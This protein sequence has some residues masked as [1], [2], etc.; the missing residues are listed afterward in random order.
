MH[1]EKHDRRNTEPI[2]TV[3]HGVK[4]ATFFCA[5]GT[6]DVYDVD[7]GEPNTFRKAHFREKLP[8]NRRATDPR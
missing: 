8:P 3:D 4:E 2:V 7:P 1:G 5:D 6:R